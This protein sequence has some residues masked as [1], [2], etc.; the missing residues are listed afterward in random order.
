MSSREYNWED[1]YSG[2]IRGRMLKITQEQHRCMDVLRG[3]RRD[4]QI[5][6]LEILE[7][8]QK[9]PDLDTCFRQISGPDYFDRRQLK[10]VVRLMADVE[11]W[12]AMHMHNIETELEQ[13]H[14]MIDSHHHGQYTL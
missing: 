10:M 8:E 13:L 5:L 3:I 12:H 4:K 6:D 11:N 1:H 9:Y 14:E 2:A 7:I